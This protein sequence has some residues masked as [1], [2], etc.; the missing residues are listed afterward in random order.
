[1]QEDEG[2]LMRASGTDAV[3]MLSWGLRR[4]ALVFLACLLGG[5]VL[6]P[7]VASQRVTPSDAVALVI[8]Q[9]L[10]MDLAALPRY[11]E[12]V[13]DNGEV[14]R[15]V[16]AQFGDAGDYADVVPERVSLVAE[17]DS[18]V[19]QVIGHDVDQET[20]A[21]IAD[22]AANAFVQALNAAGAGVGVFAL[23]SPAE[24]AGE[25]QTGPSRLIAVIVGLVAGL[26]LGLAA[27]SVLLVVRRPVI[28]PTDAEEAT[29]LP[30]LGIVTVPRTRRG[31]QA[32]P[33]QFAGIVPVCRRLL[34]L[35]T[36]TLVLVSRPHDRRVREQLSVALASLLM[37]VREVHFVGPVELQAKLPARM[38]AAGVL[39]LGDDRNGGRPPVDGQLTI[40]DSREPLDL[41]RPPQ[42]TAT[43]LIVPVGIR[44]SK[45]R[46]AVVEHLGGSA[47]ARILLV[48]RGRR[49]RVESLPR[50]EAAPPAEQL[51]PASLGDPA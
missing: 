12:A 23:Q 30:A 31:A 38:T 10:D 46:A 27:V 14:A 50:P 15:A 13:F 25:P 48:K 32:R 8:A 18:V 11:G 17:Q 43:V 21:A 9:R 4:Y 44:T 45:L 35:S 49:S 3:G 19:F 33:D 26:V 37:R 22:V 28:D 39:P 2:T 7:Y 5:A 34:G 1:V 47:E 29:D 16:V 51:Q 40:V 42:E 24:P 6:A 36:P 41:V 20:A